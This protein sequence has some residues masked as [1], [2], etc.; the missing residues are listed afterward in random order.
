MNDFQRQR[1]EG[2]TVGEPWQTD[3]KMYG[4]ITVKHG[5]WHGHS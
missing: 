3:G 2:T 1:R 5:P 4:V